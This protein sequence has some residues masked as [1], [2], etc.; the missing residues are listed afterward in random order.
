MSNARSNAEMT[1]DPTLRELSDE[2]QKDAQGGYMIII[3]RYLIYF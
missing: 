3:I 1:L 2:E